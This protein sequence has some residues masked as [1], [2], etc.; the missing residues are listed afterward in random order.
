MDTSCQ[1]IVLQYTQP[2]NKA[3]SPFLPDGI[4]MKEILVLSLAMKKPTIENYIAHTNKLFGENAKTFL[5]LYP[6]LTDSQAKRAAQDFAGD[7]FIAYSTWKWVDMQLKTGGSP[8]FRYEFDQTLPLPT[9]AKPGTEPRA[10][11]AWEIEYVFRVLSSKNLPWTPEDY[12]LSELISSY[13]TNFAKTGDPNGPWF[14]A[15]AC[16]RQRRRLP[17]HA[18]QSQSGVRA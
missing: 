6:A 13:W 4:W 14:A 16:I 1:K 11:H 8:V 12:Q 2:G 10:A 17:G 5:K 15:V 9:E 3:T 18:P 7:K